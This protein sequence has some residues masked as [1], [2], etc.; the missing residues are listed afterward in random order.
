MS[1]FGL[2]DLAASYQNN[3]QNLRIKSDLAR[4][5]QELATGTRSDLKA[6]TGGDLSGFSGIESALAKMSAYK[7]AANEAAFYGDTVQQSLGQVQDLG[8]AIAPTLITSG[9]IGT[10]TAIQSA[11]ADARSKFSSVVS[12]MNTRLADRALFSG[13]A[14][15]T[16]ALASADNILASLETA[17]AAETTASG[18]ET[19]VDDWFDASGGGFE[20]VGYLGATT[21]IAALRI[22]MHETAEIQ[23]RADDQE[24][25]EVLKGFALAALVDRGALS[26]QIVEQADLISRAGTQLMA[27]DGGLAD[28]RA[29]IGA[30]ES[31]IEQA[32]VRNTAETAA[33]QTARTNILAID[34]FETATMLQT[35]EVQLETL[36]AMTAR[37]SRLS[38]VDYLR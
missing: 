38:L 11:A 2:G 13:V 36:Y 37:L 27:A 19:V 22:G 32:I 17:I 18:I 5:S 9:N 3:V 4:L 35:T 25:R 6:A 7:I 31:Q 14:V 33:L 34:P 26:G 28:L 21:D 20:T 16:A 15:N 23:V 24:I 10:T 1:S 8:A 29:Q 30:T 12:L